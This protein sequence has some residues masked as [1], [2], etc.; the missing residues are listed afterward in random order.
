[1]FKQEDHL[2]QVGFLDLLSH[3]AQLSRRRTKVK[4]SKMAFVAQI[5]LF[6]S[7]MKAHILKSCFL[8]DFWNKTFDFIHLLFIA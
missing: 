4:F 8:N 7:K 2:D 1:L 6:T 3:T 5:H